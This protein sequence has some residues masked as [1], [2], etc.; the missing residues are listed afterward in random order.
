VYYTF[1]AQVFEG[2][3]FYINSWSGYDFHPV[4]NEDGQFDQ[5]LICH[6]LQHED[7]NRFF[8]IYF[9]RESK[10]PY[11]QTALKFYST[12]VG[13]DCSCNVVV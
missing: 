13:I 11:V 9:E 3:E 4:M 8:K 5:Y 12:V 6:G 10:L 2:K 1:Y 7:V